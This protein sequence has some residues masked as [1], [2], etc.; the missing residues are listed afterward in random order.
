M[1]HASSII[2]A[3]TLMCNVQSSAGRPVMVGPK[4]SLYGP[5]AS[6][7]SSLILLHRLRLNSYNLRTH[8][9][10]HEHS[11]IKMSNCT[12]HSHGLRLSYLFLQSFCLR[13]FF[14]K[15]T[16]NKYEDCNH[17]KYI[18][19]QMKILYIFVMPISF[20]NVR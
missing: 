13:F 3:H 18:I 6:N 9:R 5:L 19:N 2:S 7:L 4:M 12:Q 1:V 10:S 16:Q 17:E 14:S 20:S 15:K 11:L 8:N